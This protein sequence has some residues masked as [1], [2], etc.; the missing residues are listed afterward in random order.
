MDPKTQSAGVGGGVCR[1]AA[2]RGAG[3]D[4]SDGQAGLNEL[5]G[6]N[7]LNED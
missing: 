7:G 4:G 2:K 6:L 5:N 3:S 1:G